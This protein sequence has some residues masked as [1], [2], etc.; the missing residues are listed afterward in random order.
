MAFIPGTNGP[1]RL[2]GTNAVDTIL[3]MGPTTRSMAWVVWTA[4]MAE[5]GATVSTAAARGM[6]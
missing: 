4:F 6:P 3:A 5:R 1:D 2:T